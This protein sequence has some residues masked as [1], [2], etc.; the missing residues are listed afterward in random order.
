MQAVAYV[1]YALHYTC[2]S[3]YENKTHFSFSGQN[4]CQTL[5]LLGFTANTQYMIDPDGPVEGVDPFI[6]YCNSMD[7][8][9]N[10][11]MMIV[12]HDTLKRT[13]VKGYEA[14][15]SYKKVIGYTY[16]TIKQL[17]TLVQM[18]AGKCQQQIIIEC[19]DSGLYCS[20]WMNSNGEKRQYW[21][22]KN[23]GQINVCGSTTPA[24]TCNCMLED[25]IWHRDE[26][27]W[28]E[29]NDLPVTELCFGDTGNVP[30]DL[31]YTLGKLIC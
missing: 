21:G 12:N 13:R 10:Q 1:E 6:V 19:K 16:A 18:M 11:P 24:S 31:Y 30:E 15:G 17:R 22:G 29:V 23:T 3:T 2:S 28:T 20:W 8:P 25:G 7:V 9:N 4:N 14:D 5:K 26:G 27:N